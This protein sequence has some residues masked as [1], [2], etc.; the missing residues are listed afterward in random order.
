MFVAGDGECYES[1]LPNVAAALIVL[2]ISAD[3]GILHP[4]HP[5]A[6]VAV[7]VWANNQVEMIR[8]QTVSEDRHGN[9]Y[10]GMANGFEKSLIIFVFVKNLASA[11]ASIENVIANPANRGSSKTRHGGKNT[12]I[13]HRSQ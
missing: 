4:V 3:M 7:L 12:E 1:P 13:A 10:A 5:S 9:F 11:V 6:Q 8:H 2:M